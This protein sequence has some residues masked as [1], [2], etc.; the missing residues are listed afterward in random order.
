MNDNVLQVKERN[1]GKRD[2]KLIRKQKMVPG[3]FYTAKEPSLPIA[4]AEV[5]LRKTLARKSALITLQMP[6]GN[7][8][9]C[10]VREIQR[11]PVWGNIIH[12]DL[13]GITRG[14]KITVTV[15]LHLVGSPVGVKEGGILEHS[16]RELEIECFPKDIPSHL[17]WDVSVLKVGESVRVEKLSFEN[18]RIITDPKIAIATVVPP[19]VEKVVAP[20]EEAEVEGEE[21]PEE[22]EETEE[23][24]EKKEKP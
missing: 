4:I 7:E 13:L 19:K 2:V 22:G 9:E 11:D 18:I 17:E 14:Q 1:S 16:V 23:D 6:D 20:V 5:E 21:K 10:V 8:R 12:I 15:P 3:I 24:K